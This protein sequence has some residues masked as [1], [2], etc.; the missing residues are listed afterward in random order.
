MKSKFFIVIAV[1]ALT[2]FAPAAW[3]CNITISDLT[4]G[5][6]TVT[7]STEFSGVTKTQ[8]VEYASGSGTWHGFA[9]GTPKY[10]ILTEADGTTAS[11]FLKVWASSCDTINFVFESD[12]YASFASDVAA[13]PTGTPTLRETGSLQNVTSQFSTILCTSGVSISVGSD[14]SDPD[15]PVPVPPSVLLLGTG[16]VGLVGLRR[17]RKK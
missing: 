17:F 5:N 9:T 4:E 15:N 13:L 16:L 10:L 12:G 2:C 14:L 3:A 11:D 1:L 8:N 7:F 6:I